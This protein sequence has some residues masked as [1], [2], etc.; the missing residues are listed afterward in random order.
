M[1]NL[2]ASQPEIYKAFKDGKFSVQLTKSNPFGRIPVDQTTEVTVNRD[3]QT[4][5]RGTT[6]FSLKPG[7]VSK[8]YLT[9]EYRSA[10]LTKLRNMVQHNRRCTDYPDLQKSRL[11]KDEELVTSV[12]ETL[13][14]WANPF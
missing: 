6:K 3:T 11:Q 8:Y 1:T 12:E 4:Q 13:V 14:N 5:Q 2:A 10:F 7:A 9:A